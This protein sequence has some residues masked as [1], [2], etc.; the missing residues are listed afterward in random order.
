MLKVSY[1]FAAQPDA[2]F[3]VKMLEAHF[4]SFGDKTKEDTHKT[5]DA[6]REKLIAFDDSYI[7]LD[8]SHHTDSDEG[9][10]LNDNNLKVSVGRRNVSVRNMIK[11]ATIYEGNRHR[12]DFVEVVE[13]DGVKKKR[14]TKLTRP[15]RFE[16]KDTVFSLN[17]E[18]A[19]AD[20]IVFD[21]LKDHED[22]RE[23][24][25]KGGYNVFADRQY[26]PEKSAYCVADSLA[27]YVALDSEGVFDEYCQDFE[28]LKKA[29]SYH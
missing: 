10:S 12:D 18:Q 29:R 7:P 23:M 26:S 5:D 19:L 17:E 1:A 15:I 21:A 13:V 27:L 20:A 14:R 24:I 8:V 16:Y 3:R 25:A 11:N 28:L 4:T 2:H 9:R 22:L 6:L